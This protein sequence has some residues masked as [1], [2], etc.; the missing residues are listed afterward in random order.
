[1][2]N[3]KALLTL[4]ETTETQILLQKNVK[5]Y[6]AW[7]RQNV[8]DAPTFLLDIIYIRVGTKLYRQ[9]VEIPM[10]TNCATL[11]AYLFL[12]FF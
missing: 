12:L 3:E 11:V 2:R 1:M 5:I 4:H 9:V 7:S 8:C 6:H 10:G